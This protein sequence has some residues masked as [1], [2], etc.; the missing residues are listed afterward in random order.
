[1][2]LIPYQ[3]ELDVDSLQETRNYPLC[4]YILAVELID[5]AFG[6]IDRLK[7][8]APAQSR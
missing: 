2:V 7:Y 6:A 1:M 4:G 8:D 5:G 3:C